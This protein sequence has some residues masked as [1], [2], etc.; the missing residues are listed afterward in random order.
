MKKR[1]TVG[2]NFED[3]VK[4]EWLKQQTKMS[5]SSLT[6]D[7]HARALYILF[8]RLVVLGCFFVCFCFVLTQFL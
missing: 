1:L 2:L 8:R 6:S 4:M 3:S 5:V 7:I